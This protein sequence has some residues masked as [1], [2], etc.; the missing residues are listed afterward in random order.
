MLRWGHG[1]PPDRPA[2]TDGEKRRSYME[3]L[4]KTARVLD[5]VARIAFWVTMVVGALL[6]LLW[7]LNLRDPFFTKYMGGLLMAGNLNFTL[8]EPVNFPWGAMLV[9]AALELAVYG[10]TVQIFRRVPRPMK[11]GRPFDGAARQLRRL[12]WVTLAANLVLSL[13][14]Y[15]VQLRF[16][17]GLDLQVFLS[18]R[19][20]SCASQVHLDLG[21]LGPGI[22]LLL[23]SFVFHYGE[24]LQRQADETL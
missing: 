17:R 5:V 20:L 24:E 9:L 19:V 11:E 21:F 7:A 15:L 14:E 22:F 10:C 6:L 13:G 12:A 18:E 3:S 4:R 1:K 2:G 8:A 23:L 16:Y